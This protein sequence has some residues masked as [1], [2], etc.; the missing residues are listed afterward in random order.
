[1]AMLFLA[2][3]FLFSGCFTHQ[4]IVGDGP[5]T[6]ITEETREWFILWG[7]VPINEVDSSEMAAGA[8]DYKITTEHNALDVIISFFTSIVT[9][10]PRTVTVTR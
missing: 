1:M 3:M 7:L 10:Y 2:S 4:H 5:Q 6:G 8:S 9:V